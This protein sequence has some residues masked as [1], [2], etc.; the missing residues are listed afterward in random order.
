[1]GRYMF[2]AVSHVFLGILPVITSVM[3]IQ[4]CNYKSDFIADINI[5]L[6]KGLYNVMEKTPNVHFYFINEI[7]NV[8]L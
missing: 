7:Y 3:V 8:Y 2:F 6:F 1:M 4:Y 5:G